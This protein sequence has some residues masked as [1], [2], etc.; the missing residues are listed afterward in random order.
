MGQVRHVPCVAQCPRD[1]LR[2]L[3]TT[4][5][6][7]TIAGLV[8]GTRNE[9][10][11]LGL[12]LGTYNGR[13]AL[14]LGLLDHELGTLRVLLRDLLLFDGFGKLLAERQVGLG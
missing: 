8:Q 7:Q 5:G 3:N 2:R 6:Q 13:L 12:A 4:H 10:S 14:L 9:R 11:R 1:V